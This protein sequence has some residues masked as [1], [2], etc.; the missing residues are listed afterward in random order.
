M[1]MKEFSLQN[2]DSENLVRFQSHQLLAGR[3][4][5][6]K[7]GIGR[8]KKIKILRYKIMVPDVIRIPVA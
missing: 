7:R 5:L 8:G 6:E 2:T 3:H 4:T 1:K